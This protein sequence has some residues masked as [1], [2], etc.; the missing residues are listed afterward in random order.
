MTLEELVAAADAAQEKAWAANNAAWAAWQAAFD[1]AQNA[2]ALVN[3]W[4]RLDK[5]EKIPLTWNPI[6]D[7]LEKWDAAKE[8][9]EAEAKFQAAH[10]RAEKQL[11]NNRRIFYDR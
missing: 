2:R 10:D 1:V 5:A 9:P 11:A 3:N 8:K 7:A 6:R 4:V